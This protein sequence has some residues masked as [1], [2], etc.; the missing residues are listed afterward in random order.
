MAFHDTAAPHDDVWEYTL[1]GFG[2]F[3]EQRSVAFTEP[4]PASRVCSICGRVPSSSV[5]LACCHVLCDDCRSKAF[6]LGMV[7]PFDGKASTEGQL[8]RLRFELSELEQLHVVCMVGG[9]KCT[10]F[11][12]KLSA[13]RDHL[14]ECLSGDV[15]CAICCRS[16]AREAAVNHY[17]Q[18]RGGNAPRHSVINALVHRA[19][20]KIQGI[21]DDVESLVQRAANE[22]DGDGNLVNVVNGLVERLATAHRVLS[23]AQE[24]GSA[25]GV[26]KRQRLNHR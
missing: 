26:R 21:K 22:R 2:D 11:A 9:R 25:G 13:L 7:C 14:R 24:M 18:C 10:T 19:V 6:E 8:V 12:G 4:M 3:L 15:K 20:E 17:R 1:T 5:L 16:I 23:E